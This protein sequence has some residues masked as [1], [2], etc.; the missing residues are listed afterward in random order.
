VADGG[1]IDTYLSADALINADIAVV[2]DAAS[3]ALINIL[4]GLT[5][6]QQKKIILWL[7]IFVVV[8]AS[9]S[10]N[11]LSGVW[12]ALQ[13]IGKINIPGGGFGELE[14]EP[15][16][17]GLEEVNIDSVSSAVSIMDC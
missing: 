4:R 5:V 3:T 6:A 10:N 1:L 11:V 16:C 2:A 7:A 15:K 14:P 9:Y 8:E 17:T 13:L 12:S